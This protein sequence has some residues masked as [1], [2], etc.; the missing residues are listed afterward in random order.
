M[1][2]PRLLCTGHVIR[3]ARLCEELGLRS[4]AAELRSAGSLVR[5]RDVLRK[6]QADAEANRSE[7]LLDEVVHALTACAAAMAEIEHANAT[8]R[9]HVANTR[10]SA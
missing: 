7:R 1:V 8:E 5:T 3:S 2:S 9:H 6:V 4:L 10:R